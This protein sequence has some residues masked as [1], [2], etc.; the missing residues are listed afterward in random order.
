VVNILSLGDETYGRRI[1]T[2]TEYKRVMGVNGQ[3]AGHA[4][5]CGASE[6]FPEC[7]F[8]INRENSDTI[9]DYGSGRSIHHLLFSVNSDKG[10]YSVLTNSFRKPVSEMVAEKTK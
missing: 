10:H 5:L 9:T 8:R 1:Q 7:L 3:Y 6:V 4:E 2:A